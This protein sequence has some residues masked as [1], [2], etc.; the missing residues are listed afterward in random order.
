MFRAVINDWLAVGVNVALRQ[1]FND[2]FIIGEMSYYQTPNVYD[3][4]II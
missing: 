4:T 1:A 3:Q 2:E